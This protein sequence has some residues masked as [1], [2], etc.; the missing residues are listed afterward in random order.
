M[1]DGPGAGEVWTRNGR[2]IDEGRTRDRR[3]S[4]EAWAKRGRTSDEERAPSQS[5]PLSAWKGIAV[6]ILSTSHFPFLVKIW[7]SESSSPFPSRT[8]SSLRGLFE[9]SK[10]RKS[11][12][13]SRIGISS[14]DP[15]IPTN[16]R[17]QG[18][19]KP[20][21]ATAPTS[22]WRVT[23]LVGIGA[24]SHGIDRISCARSGRLL[25][26]TGA[27][28]KKGLLRIQLESSALPCNGGMTRRVKCHAYEPRV[29]RLV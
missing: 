5:A 6:Y 21:V 19:G 27:E 23:V 10:V 1:K 13:V 28:G 22:T 2:V 17:G 14:R 26:S 8:F 24:A 11:I 20:D 3:G 16:P 18:R 7:S 9:L 15:S 29:N 12:L 4:G 25:S